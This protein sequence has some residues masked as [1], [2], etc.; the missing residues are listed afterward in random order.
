MSSN[1]SSS[2]LQDGNAF[3]VGNSIEQDIETHELRIRQYI[4]ISHLDTSVNIEQLIEEFTL[5]RE[6]GERSE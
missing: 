5:N 3:R 1:N 6:Q 4:E 2:I